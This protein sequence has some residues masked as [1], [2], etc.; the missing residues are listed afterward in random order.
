ME[1]DCSAGYTLSS[2]PFR[3]TT[4]S[5]G[6]FYVNG[7]GSVGI[8]DGSPTYKLDVNGTGRFTG[9]LTGATA[10]FSGE[11][12]LTVGL[13]WHDPTSSVYGRLGYGSGFVYV[14]ALGA[15][16]ILQL[17][18]GGSTACTFAANHDAT[19][20]GAMTVGGA[21]LPAANGTHNLGSSG[22][23]W[24]NAYLEDTAINGTLWVGGALTGTGAAG[25]QAIFR[26]NEATASQRAGG[27]FSSAGSATAASRYARMFL[28]ADGGDFS[29]VDYFTIEKFGAVTTTPAAKSNLL[30]IVIRIC[31]FG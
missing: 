18:S 27:G 10:A 15:T 19:F 14:G 5:G 21:L 17:M 6:P 3:V 24:K 25:N 12:D 30:I 23:Y 16:G 1:V 13:D 26:T 2:Q 11:V 8:G 22:A 28:D 9:A 20:T 31:R 29:G 7:L 4:P